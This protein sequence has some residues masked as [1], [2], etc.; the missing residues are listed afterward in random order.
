GLLANWPAGAELTLVMGRHLVRLRPVVAEILQE[1][2]AVPVRCVG[3]C[4]EVPALLMTHDL[5]ISK[6]GG[7][8][9]HECFAAGVPVM[10][11]YIIPGQEEGNAE[12]LEQLGC[13]CRCLD[14]DKT[15]PL[16]AR[17]VEGGGLAGMRLAMARHR[18]PGGAVTVA[19]EV[20]ERL[21]QPAL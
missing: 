20:L 8:T 4:R 15:G 16:L 14:P 3:W 2:P 17:L 10:V 12:L 7:A 18:R 21:R 19:R 1:Y 9:V 5:V 6:A 13:G 11:N